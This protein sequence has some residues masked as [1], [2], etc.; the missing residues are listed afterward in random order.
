M[1]KFKRKKPGFILGILLLILGA[2]GLISLL[3]F[4]NSIF[5]LIMS[6]PIWLGKAFAFCIEFCQKYQ[7]SK[8]ILTFLLILLGF[9]LYKLKKAALIIFG[10]LE[11]VGGGFIIWAA[12]EIPS[13]QN[14]TNAIAL[15]AGLFL[16]VQGAENYAKGYIIEKTKK[17]R[18]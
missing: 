12:V 11:F 14:L 9:S 17:G 4:T 10:V 8:Y 1:N 3:L 2:F 15:G 5:V 16:I 13:S 18:Q 7:L 6:W